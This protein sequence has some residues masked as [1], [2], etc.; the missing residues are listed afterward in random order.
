M[1]V[2]HDPREP[3]DVHVLRS[4]SW[5]RRPRSPRARSR[6]DGGS[7]RSSS[8]ASSCRWSST[9]SS[10]TGCGAAAG[11]ALSASDF[12]LGHGMVDFAGSSVVHMTGGVTALAGVLIIGPRIGK[13]RKDGTIVMIQGHNLP[14]S[15]AGTLI[16]GFGWFGF[17][18]GSTLSATEPRIAGD[19]RRTRRSPRRPAALTSLGY[20]WQRYR[21]P[22]L[23][24]A[25]NGFIGGLVAITASC[26][27]VAPPAAALIGVVAG[28]LVALCVGGLERRLPHRRSRGRHRR[29]RRL[30]SVGGARGRSLRGRELRRGLERRRRPGPRTCSSATRGQLAAQAIGAVTNFVFVFGDGVR[31]LPRPR[32]THRQPRRRRDRD[33]G[34]RRRRDGV[35][36]VP[37]GLSFRARASVRGLGPD[38]AQSHEARSEQD[39]PRARHGAPLRA[40]REARP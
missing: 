19:R 28:L 9:R 26:A 5:T 11:S 16:L 7:R 17:N 6:S 10:P 21:S 4:C 34:P 18:A 3:R 38:V 13:F 31:V 1:S 12:G 33:G 32:S 35:G 22:D 27:F 40:G 2:A 39:R 30:R 8:T 15:V 25:C 36:R 37:G 20:I 14:M 29:P 24:M 23:A